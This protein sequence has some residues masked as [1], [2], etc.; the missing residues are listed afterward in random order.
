MT[1]AGPDGCIQ[2]LKAKRGST[3]T[4]YKRKL[5]KTEVARHV[6]ERTDSRG[7][8]IILIETT[9]SDGTADVVKYKSSQG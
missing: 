6:V 2:V 7:F 3:A 1:E 4:G 9:H 5:A 8:P